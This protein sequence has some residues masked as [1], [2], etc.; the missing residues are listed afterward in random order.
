MIEKKR[1]RKIKRGRWNGT[2]KERGE[3]FI[4]IEYLLCDTQCV[5]GVSRAS[6]CVYFQPAGLFDKTE[7]QKDQQGIR[8]QE[9]EREQVWNETWE[10]IPDSALTSCV[11]LLPL[12]N[13][14][15]HL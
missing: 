8:E 14:I 6:S 10:R 13:Y 3:N 15:P 11:I 2:K 5:R 12:P 4:F 9:M 7:V 1:E